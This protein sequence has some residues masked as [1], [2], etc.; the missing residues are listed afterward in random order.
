[1]AQPGIR[2]YALAREWNVLPEAILEAARRLGLNMTS[3]LSLLDPRQR[4]AVENFF[5]RSPPEDPNGVPSRLDPTGPN[6]SVL[7]AA[8]V[9]S[10]VV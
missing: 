6:P 7:I 1:M 2:V 3:R 10:H 5:R 9:R 8:A 4:A